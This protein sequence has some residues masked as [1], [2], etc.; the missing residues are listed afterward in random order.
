MLFTAEAIVL[1]LVPHPVYFGGQVSEVLIT[2][3]DY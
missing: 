1:N 2:H 3:S